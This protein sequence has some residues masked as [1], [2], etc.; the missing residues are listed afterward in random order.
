[1]ILKRWAWPHLIFNPQVFSKG[2]RQYARFF[3]SCILFHFHKDSPWQRWSF[4]TYKWG[5]SGPDKVNNLP[6]WQSWDLNLSTSYDSILRHLP[7]GAS[8][9]GE[10]V[11]E[12]RGRDETCAVTSALTVIGSGTLG[13]PFSFQFL[14]LKNTD[15]SFLSG[16][17]CED[18][19]S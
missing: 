17:C 5:N 19:I 10:Q 15:F 18:Q 14:H 12:A 6:K 16:G 2:A 13:Q 4:P 1:M 11:C 8:S 3:T 9:V 7:W